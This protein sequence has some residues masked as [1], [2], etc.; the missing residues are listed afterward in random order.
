VRSVSPVGH[1]GSL[2]RPSPDLG[3]GRRGAGRRCRAV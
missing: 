1:R 2:H 3:A